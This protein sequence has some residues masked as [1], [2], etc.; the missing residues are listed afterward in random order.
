MKSIIDKEVA[1]N[2]SN[3]IEIR[4]LPSDL[5]NAIYRQSWVEMRKIFKNMQKSR[6]PDDELRDKKNVT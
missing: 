3:P 4:R 1:K 5:L 2:N 6:A